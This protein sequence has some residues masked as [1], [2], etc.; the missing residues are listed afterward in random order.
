MGL[1][2]PAT[3]ESQ[4]SWGGG[5]ATWRMKAAQR[6]FSPSVH[7]SPVPPRI[8]ALTRDAPGP[9][10]GVV[11]RQGGDARAWGGRTRRGVATAGAW[12]N[13]ARGSG[14]RT[15]LRSAG[16]RSGAEA[17]AGPRKGS[18]R[19]GAGRRRGGRLGADAQ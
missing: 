7:P 15:P 11:Q 12:R 17:G 13:L 14:F 16:G 4:P 9:L 18:A 2:A 10:A 5:A 19:G 8:P 1:R 3:P 6:A